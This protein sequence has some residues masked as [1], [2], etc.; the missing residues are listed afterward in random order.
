MRK[1]TVLSLSLLFAFSIGFTSCK[2]E[3]T[4][5]CT[6]VVKDSQGNTQSKSSTSVTAEHSSKSDAEDWCSGRSS[7][8]GSGGSSQTTCELE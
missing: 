8:Q 5:Q 4:C 2:K 7:S 3:Y 1:L 6:T